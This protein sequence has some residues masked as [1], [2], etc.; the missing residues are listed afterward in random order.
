MQRNFF[1]NS[2]FSESC[3]SHETHWRG[4]YSYPIVEQKPENKI[5]NPISECVLNILAIVERFLS[6]SSIP[7]SSAFSSL[8]SFTSQCLQLTLTR[9]VIDWIW[10]LLVD[11]LPKVSGTKIVERRTRVLWLEQYFFFR[12][13]RFF[14]KKFPRKPGWSLVERE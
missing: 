8:F 5:L 6:F 7:F 11:S 2:F 12:S 4:N 13:N 9:D 14:P 1:F 10:I 3:L